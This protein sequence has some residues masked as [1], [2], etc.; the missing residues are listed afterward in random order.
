MTISMSLCVYLTYLSSEVFR[1]LPTFKIEFCFLMSMYWI[2]VLCQNILKILLPIIT[3]NIFSQSVAFFL[4]SHQ[5]SLSKRS[6]QSWWNSNYYFMNYF[7]L[8]LRNLCLTQ[9]HRS[10][11]YVFFEQLCTLSFIFGY[12]IHFELIFADSLRNKSKC[13][14]LFCNAGIWTFVHMNNC[15]NTIC[16]ID[17]VFFTEL[18]WTFVENHMFMYVWVYFWTLFCSII[19]FVYPST[20]N[21]LSW[22]CTFT[23]SLQINVS[24][25]T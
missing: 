6:F 23:V 24:S 18:I 17:H 21:I 9:S 11:P 3:A 10:F 7:M 1:A 2:W 8:H 22:Y 14:V 19:L 25:P 13:F 4:L 5:S 16:K 15:S 12:I 20:N